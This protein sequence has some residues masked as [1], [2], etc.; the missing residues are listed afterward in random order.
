MMP[1]SSLGCLSCSTVRLF[2]LH[3][4]VLYLYLYVCTTST[5]VVVHTCTYL[6]EFIYE[7][8]VSVSY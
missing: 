5:V 7:Y 3:V 6:H 2:V 4:L 1:A 8:F